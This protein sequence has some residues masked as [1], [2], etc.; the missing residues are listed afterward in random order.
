MQ[1]T[2]TTK[3]SITPLNHRLYPCAALGAPYHLEIYHTKEQP[4]TNIGALNNNTGKFSF[5][6]GDVVD[7]APKATI[8]D[9]TFLINVIANTTLV[10]LMNNSHIR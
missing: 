4:T 8:S 10:T 3:K 7:V 2:I 9:R 6:I 1:Q 5:N